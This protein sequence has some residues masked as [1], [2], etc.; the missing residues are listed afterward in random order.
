M[1]KNELAIQ[2]FFAISTFAFHSLKY[3]CIMALK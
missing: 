3:F 1:T 2:I